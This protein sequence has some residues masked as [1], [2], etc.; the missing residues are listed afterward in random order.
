M[1]LS[2]EE[3]TFQHEERDDFGGFED[4]RTIPNVTAKPEIRPFQRV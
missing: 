3:E 1:L 2:K 4:A